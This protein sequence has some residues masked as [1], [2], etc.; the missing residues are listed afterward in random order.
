MFKPKSDLHDTNCL[1]TWIVHFGTKVHPAPTPNQS[2]LSVVNRKAPQTTY[3]RILK[4][5][6]K[7]KPIFTKKS[8]VI[9]NQ[10]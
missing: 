5:L 6:V 4:M 9:T 2:V 10:W 7:L 8:Q 1:K 3:F